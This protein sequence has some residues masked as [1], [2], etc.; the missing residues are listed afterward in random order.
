MTIFQGP[1][2]DKNWA[3]MLAMRQMSFKTGEEMPG[4]K[5][6]AKIS[7]KTTVLT[8]LKKIEQ[9]PPAPPFRIFFLLFTLGIQFLDQTEV[10]FHFVQV[11]FL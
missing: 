2:E 3:S 11:M 10:E 8:S 4:V 7:V 9:G 5:S 6:I 1:I